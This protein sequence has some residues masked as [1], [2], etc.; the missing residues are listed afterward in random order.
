[1][2]IRTFRAA[3]VTSLGWLVGCSDPTAPT[4][5]QRYELV[6]IDGTA[7]PAQPAAFTYRVL[8]DTLEFGVV[9]ARWKPRPL[10]RATRYLRRPDG[11]IDMEEW[12]YTY[13]AV[14]R[15]TFGFRALCADGDLAASCIDGTATATI[16]GATLT[17]RFRVES[18][19]LLRYRR[20]PGTPAPT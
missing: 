8:A 1:V 5:G 17:I 11:S 19:G 10:A 15:S 13:D 20:I 9:S 6:S 2:T 4:R 12:W 18:L 14:P 3:A 16:E 7:L